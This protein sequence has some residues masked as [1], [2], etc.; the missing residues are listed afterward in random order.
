MN[1]LF[2]L[3][4][5][6][7]LALFYYC[8][9][10]EDRYP[11]EETDYIRVDSLKINRKALIVGIDGFRSDALQQEITPFMYSLQH[12]NSY[13]NINHVTEEIT[14][15][16]PNWLSMLTGVHLNKHNVD[17]NSFE[18]DNYDEY[19]PFFYYVEQANNSINTASIVNWTPI[20]THILSDYADY[21][22][23]E[24]SLIHI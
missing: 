7:L 16:G 8:S 13:Y 17:D 11:T 15:S 1:R 23:L 4:S 3:F 5:C 19:P 2:F 6:M 10:D 20:N 9:E 12:R 18:N 22:P 14:Y 24:L 21:A